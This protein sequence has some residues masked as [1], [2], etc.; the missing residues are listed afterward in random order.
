MRKM[1]AKAYTSEDL[2]IKPEDDLFQEKLDFDV[3]KGKP[4]SI[5]A[6]RLTFFRNHPS[7]DDINQLTNDDILGYAIIVRLK[8]ASSSEAPLDDFT[9]IFE[10][11][12]RPPGIY[13]NES[14]QS[15]PNQY[16]HCFR[17]FE[18]VVGVEGSE[19]SFTFPGTFFC[20]QNLKTHVCGHAAVRMA[21]N[22]IPGFPKVTNKELNDAFAFDH[23]N[24]LVPPQIELDALVQFIESKGFSVDSIDFCANPNLD[25]EEAIYP[26]IESGFPV[27]LAI[28]NNQQAHIFTIVGHTLNSDR[29]PLP[30]VNYPGKTGYISASEWTDHYICN[31]DSTGMYIAVSADR[32]RTTIVPKF[33]ADLHVAAALGILPR[34]VRLP[35]SVADELS[36]RFFYIMGEYW[37]DPSD[38]WLSVIGYDHNRW[39]DLLFE[40]PSNVVFRT[41][42]CTRTEYSAHVREHLGAFYGCEL[43]MN[44]P[45]RFWVT[46]LSLP[47]LFA[48]NKRKL[49]DVIIRCDEPENEDASSHM[50]L[51]W[52][53]QLTSIWRPHEFFREK[54]EAYHKGLPVDTR[55]LHVSN[56]FD[57]HI[58]ILRS[59]CCYE[60]FLEW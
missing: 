48:T 54:I 40:D 17:N 32:L 21:L 15:I 9:Y 41:L 37:K 2:A 46:E 42:L 12:V 30:K 20:Q 43:L 28:G 18:T 14:F 56:L 59:G 49:G 53:P 60:R 8:D 10:A 47:D 25:Q 35:G 27:L 26:L 1:E 3:F 33:N 44:L 19:K 4:H 39:K 5:S 23:R 55:I 22:T 16:I 58:P 51:A 50:I 29:V 34:D 57:G 45:E 36:R 38:A 6:V 31:D 7:S 11:V 52:T 24:T 13:L